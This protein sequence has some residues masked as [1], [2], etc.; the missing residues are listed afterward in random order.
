MVSGLF[1]PPQVGLRRYSSSA[2]FPI[3]TWPQKVSPPRR[4]SVLLSLQWGISPVPPALFCFSMTRPSCR[5]CRIERHSAGE[6]HKLCTASRVL[7]NI[8]LSFSCAFFPGR[9]SFRL[10][11]VSVCSLATSRT[12]H[13]F[14]IPLWTGDIWY[15]MHVRGASRV[16][17]PPSPTLTTRETHGAEARPFLLRF[18]HRCP[19]ALSLSLSLPRLPGS[20]PPQH[21]D[22]TERALL[23]RRALNPSPSS[24]RGCL[25]LLTPSAS[26]RRR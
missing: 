4:P 23:C 3:G 17:R 9:I 25:R 12:L 16:T 13:S 7:P 2:R 22:V 14:R 10:P 19:F 1:P 20:V 11:A 18:F 15:W 5:A 8:P 26:A 24:Q 6:A 21:Y